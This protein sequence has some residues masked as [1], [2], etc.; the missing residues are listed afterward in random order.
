VE[1]EKLYSFGRFLLIRHPKTDI[2]EQLKLDNEIDLQYYR[3]QKV[4]E[5]DLVMGNRTKVR[6]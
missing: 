6:R 5:G 1:L 4:G 2:S 3:L